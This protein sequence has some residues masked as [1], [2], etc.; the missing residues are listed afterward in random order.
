MEH[1]LVL[2]GSGD[3]RQQWREKYNSPDDVRRSIASANLSEFMRRRP[4]HLQ[5]HQDRFE[6]IAANMPVAFLSYQGFATFLREA[7]PAETDQSLGAEVYRNLI[8]GLLHELE[9]RQLAT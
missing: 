2:L 3:F 4:S 8:L 6:Q 9:I 1:Y 7:K 5:R